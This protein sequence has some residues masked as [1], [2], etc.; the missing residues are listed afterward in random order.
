[1]KLVAFCVLVLAGFLSLGEGGSAVNPGF[2]AI[3][4][5]KALDYGNV[6]QHLCIVVTRTRYSETSELEPAILS[7]VGRLSSLRDLRVLLL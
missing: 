6:Q 2:R 5:Q 7:L 3:I 4:T 1:M